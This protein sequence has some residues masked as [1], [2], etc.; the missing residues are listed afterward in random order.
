M[1]ST[2]LIE[3]I[4]RCCAEVEPKDCS[5]LVS[6]VVG[7]LDFRVGQFL[8]GRCR[9]QTTGS[10]RLTTVLGVRD[11][12]NRTKEP[13]LCVLLERAKR[14]AHLLN[15]VERKALRGLS[16]RMVAQHN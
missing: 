5:L 3:E 1:T 12:G 2:V 9:A 15:D 7:H 13:F 16:D 8:N 4:V 11:K 6:D 10:H 14:V